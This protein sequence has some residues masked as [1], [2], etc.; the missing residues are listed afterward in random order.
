ML[1][2]HVESSYLIVKQTNL[3][4]LTGI[5]T[6]GEEIEAYEL[7]TTLP[8]PDI[9]RDS[10]M[11]ISIFTGGKSTTFSEVNCPIHLLSYSTTACLCSVLQTI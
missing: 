9:D 1:A 10:A 5:S 2:R 8:K 11:G 3:S 4:M 6:L 7:E